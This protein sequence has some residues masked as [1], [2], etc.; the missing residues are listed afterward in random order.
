MKKE[1]IEKGKEKLRKKIG[2]MH[3][4]GQWSGL[5]ELMRGILHAAG[6]IVGWVLIHPLQTPSGIMSLLLLLIASVFLA[7]DEVR[8]AVVKA[9]GR[10]DW[11]RFLKWIN[12]KIVRKIWTRDSEEK[13]RATTVMSVF[14]LTIAW[15]VAPPWIAVLSALLFS[16]VDALAK[17]GKYWPVKRFDSGRARGKS[18]GGCL[19]GAFGGVIAGVWIICWHLWHTT[20][21]PFDLS[22][23]H[24]VVVYLVGIISAPLF[25]LYSGKWDNFFI[26][27]GT[28]VIMSLF[29]LL[30]TL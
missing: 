26:P 9:E 12:E 15:V 28:A 6:G 19:I 22:L 17:L 1:I 27:A 24:V 23:V 20:L 7:A 5:R 29:Y 13:Q 2:T 14:G 3:G 8:L 4:W 16:L 11:S 25:E 30:L 21:F 18:L 10:N